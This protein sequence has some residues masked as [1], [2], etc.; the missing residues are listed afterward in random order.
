MELRYRLTL[1][2]QKQ[3]KKEEEAKRNNKMPHDYYHFLFKAK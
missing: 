3:T 1:Q 2:K